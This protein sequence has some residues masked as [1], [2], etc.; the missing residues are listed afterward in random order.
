MIPYAKSCKNNCNL[1]SK[2]CIVLKEEEMQ[3]DF[4]PHIQPFIW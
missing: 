1:S 2:F 4:E 3:I